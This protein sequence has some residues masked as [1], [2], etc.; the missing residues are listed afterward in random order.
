MKSFLS[1]IA[2]F[3]FNTLFLDYSLDV[4]GSVTF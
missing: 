3:K 2:H 1:I 4:Q